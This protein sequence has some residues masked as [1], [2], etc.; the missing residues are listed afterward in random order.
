LFLLSE[1]LEGIN[2]TK[3]IKTFDPYEILEVEFNASPADIK[4]AYRYE[5]HL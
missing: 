5:S 1:S 4:R 3:Q 2:N